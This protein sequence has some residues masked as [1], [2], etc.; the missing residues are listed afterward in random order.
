MASW[1]SRRSRRLVPLEA[2]TRLVPHLR[3]DLRE[4][5]LLLLGE[6]TVD[7]GSNLAALGHHLRCQL[8]G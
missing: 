6:Q 4:L 8:G 3:L 7:L 5:R 1:R 2:L